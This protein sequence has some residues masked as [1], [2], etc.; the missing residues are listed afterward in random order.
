MVHEELVLFY[1]GMRR[2]PSHGVR[3]TFGR[4]HVNNKLKIPMFL[5]F[6]DTVWCPNSEQVALFGTFEV[7]VSL[8]HFDEM[9]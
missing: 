3:A 1:T 8:L 2:V 9:H 6:C 7:F 5:L 4:F